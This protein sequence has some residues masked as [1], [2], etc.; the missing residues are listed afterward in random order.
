LKAPVIDR[1]PSGPSLAPGSARREVLFPFPGGPGPGTDPDEDSIGEHPM[2]KPYLDP[3]ADH[4][5]CRFT[6]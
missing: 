5:H 6:C 1:H 4:W 3:F 2:S